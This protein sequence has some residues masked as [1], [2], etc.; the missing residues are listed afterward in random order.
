MDDSKG[1]NTTSLEEENQ[2]STKKFEV[3]I[4]NLKSDIPSTSLVSILVNF[5]SD[6]E[7]S[8]PA[9]RIHVDQKNGKRK[10]IKKHA[11]V[12]VTTDEEHKQLLKLDGQQELWFVV[13]GKPLKIRDAM[14]T[15]SVFKPD[16]APISAK[17]DIVP[18]HL[19]LIGSRST[20]NLTTSQ[21]QEV[22]D[23]RRPS[24]DTYARQMYHGQI[25]ERTEDRNTEY[26]KG[27]GNYMK[28]VLI[29][30]VRKYVCAFLNSDGK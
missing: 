20:P 18:T 10:T 8:V 11:Y 22:E 5:F 2:T 3:F 27:G 15:P 7:I 26:K 21:M 24:L 25:L 12:N 28:Q 14:A 19:K 9:F 23:K 13:K 16:F 30:H 1:E 29:K 6:N 17:L 4:G